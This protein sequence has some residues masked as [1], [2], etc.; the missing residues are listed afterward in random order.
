MNLIIRDQ[1][2]ELEEQTEESTTYPFLLLN[3]AFTKLCCFALPSS[4]PDQRETKVITFR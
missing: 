2:M 4:H 1:H 3:G